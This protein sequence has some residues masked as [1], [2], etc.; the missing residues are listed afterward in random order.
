[1]QRL[2]LLSALLFAGCGGSAAVIESDSAAGATA[3]D[4]QVTDWAGSLQPVEGKPFSLGVRN[5]G[6]DLYVVF[7]TRDEATVRQIVT[8]GLQVWVDP[9]GGKAQTLGLRYPM[10]F[11][12]DLGTGAFA[13]QQGSTREPGQME[14]RFNESLDELI[15][16]SDGQ[17]AE[18]WPVAEFEEMAFAARLDRGLLVTEMRIPLRHTDDFSVA[19]GAE[20]GQSIGLGFEV[21]EIDREALR[22]RFG[23]RAGGGQGARGGMGGRRRMM[24]VGGERLQFWGTVRLAGP[25]G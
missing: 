8:R 24:N 20:P 17:P 14:Q 25:G 4:A 6:Q 12:E 11:V 15:I 13:G 5:D 22:E 10:G 21:P 7:L 1:M 19:I 16:V 18:R 9:A 2:V 3:V 23:N